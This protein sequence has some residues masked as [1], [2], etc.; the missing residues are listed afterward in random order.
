MGTNRWGSWGEEYLFDNNV[1]SFFNEETGA[2]E[3]LVGTSDLDFC[4]RV[5]KGD[6]L[7]KAGFPEIAKKKYPFLIDTQI[8]A[9]QID[10]AG[11]QYPIEFP[12]EFLPEK[13]EKGEFKYEPR[14]IGD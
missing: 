13:D 10:P 6:Y 5:I 4:T 3:A 11:V 9:K 12:I 8:Y 1:Q 14:E 7:T 2:Q